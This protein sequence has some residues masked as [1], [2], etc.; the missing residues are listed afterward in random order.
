M[1]FLSLGFIC[2]CFVIMIM[3][4]INNITTIAIIMAIIDINIIVFIIVTSLKVVSISCLLQQFH[5]SVTLTSS[6]LC[7]CITFLCFCL[8]RLYILCDCLI[9]H[10]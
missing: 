8:S 7:V 3:I 1:L 10:S 6:D 9:V 2:C 5:S 4:M